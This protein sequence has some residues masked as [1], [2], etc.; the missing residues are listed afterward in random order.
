MAKNKDTSEAKKNED[1]STAAASKGEGQT[2]GTGKEASSAKNDENEDAS[3][4]VASKG[5]SQTAGTGKESSSSKNERNKDTKDKSKAGKP[6][7]SEK[8][9]TVTVRHKTKYNTYR[10]AGLILKKKAA[11]MKVTSDQLAALEA[12]SWVE[13]VSKK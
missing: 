5:E 2:A 8:L 6:A 9:I 4:A 1:A 3:T 7:E 10:R 12:D 11:E 13:V